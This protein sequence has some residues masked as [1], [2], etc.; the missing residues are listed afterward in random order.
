[1]G[2]NF[3]AHF[4]HT[5]SIKS[6]FVKYPIKWPNINIWGECSSG[7]RQYNE[8]WK[9]PGSNPTW[10]SA[11]H[12][13]TVVSLSHSQFWAILK[14]I[15]TLTQCLSKCFLQ[16]WPYVHQESCNN[17]TSLQSSWWPSGQTC[18]NTVI[19]FGLVANKLQPNSNCWL[20]EREGMR[21]IKKFGYLENEKK[22]LR[23]N[24]K[25]FSC[26]FKGYHLLIKK[27]S[28]QSLIIAWS[29]FKK[30]INLIS[31]LV[32]Q[33]EHAAFVWW[34]TLTFFV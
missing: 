17:S 8:N 16:F 1:M 14:E 23:W 18:Y 6:F 20:R 11:G 31:W 32:L 30:D 34:G 19:N 9:V 22:L 3:T 26:F 4:P 29:N 2:L 24:K 21:E 25:H 7:S 33:N 5:F 15:A 12:F 28:T 27:N 10:H 13:I